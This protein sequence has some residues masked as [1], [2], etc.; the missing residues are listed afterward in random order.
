MNYGA[1]EVFV[2]CF[3]SMWDISSR[4]S[5]LVVILENPNWPMD[6]HE[7]QRWIHTQTS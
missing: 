1:M 5:R 6:V 2:M 4:E 7:L 3:Q